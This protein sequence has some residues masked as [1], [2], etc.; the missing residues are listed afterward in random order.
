MSILNQV[1]LV[2]I[3]I[4]DLLIFHTNHSLWLLTNVSD[5]HTL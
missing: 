1:I 5:Y 4:I 2:M 3:D